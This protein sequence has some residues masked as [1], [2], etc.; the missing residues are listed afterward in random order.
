MSKQYT[1]LRAVSETLSSKQFQS[2]CHTLLLHGVQQNHPAKDCAS[3]YQYG[4][5]KPFNALKINGERFSSLMSF[6]KKLILPMFRL[7]ALLLLRVNEVKSWG[8][9]FHSYE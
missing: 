9:S 7:D 5:T 3:V 4:V 6:G 8:T 2:Q 1:F